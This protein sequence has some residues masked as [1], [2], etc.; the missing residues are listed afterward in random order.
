MMLRVT[1]LSQVNIFIITKIAHIAS[2]CTVYN[3]AAVLQCCSVAVLLCSCAALLSHLLLRASL[4]L[5]AR[6][7]PAPLESLELH[8]A[9]VGRLHGERR[10]TGSK[11]VHHSLCAVH[12][13]PP[14]PPLQSP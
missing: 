4:H 12:C 8:G 9:G 2:I 6:V 5:A 7:G 11:R 1:G 14:V 10:T 13:L 3:L